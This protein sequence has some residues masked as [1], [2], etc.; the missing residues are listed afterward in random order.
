MKTILSALA[1]TLALACNKPAELPVSYHADLKTPQ[2]I[3]V[4]AP[5]WIRK[6]DHEE[7]ARVIDEYYNKFNQQMPQSKP[8][9]GLMLKI[10]EQL[11]GC[12][13][14]NQI[15]AGFHFM[16]KN[17]IY[18]VWSSDTSTGIMMA[19]QENPLLALPHELAHWYLEQQE[20]RFP[21]WM[22]SAINQ[23]WKTAPAYEGDLSQSVGVE[24]G[25]PCD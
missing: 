13:Y 7:L 9:T 16:G 24:S 20:E 6:Q 3:Y 4:D 10:S 14:E 17:F 23:V 11:R 2:G 22:D 25:Q 21:D 1:L 12:R 5:T 19:R 18:T 8:T 15:V